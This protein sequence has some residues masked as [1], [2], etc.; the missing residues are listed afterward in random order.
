MVSTRTR[1]GSSPSKP[2]QAEM[3]VH[4]IKHFV[5][6]LVPGLDVFD[7]LASVVFGESDFYGGVELLFAFGGM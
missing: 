1:A 7:F 3:L 2:N 4:G 5:L 6:D